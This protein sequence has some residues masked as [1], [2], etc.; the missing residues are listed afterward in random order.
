MT[1]KKI[2]E[3]P[4][5]LTEEVVYPID[6]GTVIERYGTIVI[7]AP[8]RQESNTIEG[9]IGTLSNETYDSP[10]ELFDT[11][12]GNVSDEYIG[13]KYYDDRGNNI[14]EMSIHLEGDRGEDDPDI[15]F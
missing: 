7:E 6:Q 11:I 9:I 8:N 3:L 14:K 10:D 15:S 1:S 2:E 13:R 5:F 12:I 4:A